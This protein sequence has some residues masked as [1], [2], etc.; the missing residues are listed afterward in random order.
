MTEKTA[1]IDVMRV[2]RDI[3]ERFSDRPSH[4]DNDDID[5]V[6]SFRQGWKEVMEGDTIPF[7]EAM[8]QLD[9]D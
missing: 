8:K 9:E 6:E 4:D 5:P 1:K 2:F 3:F 7:D